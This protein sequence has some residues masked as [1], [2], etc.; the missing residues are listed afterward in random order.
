ML[1]I[2]GSYHE[3]GGQIVRTALGLSVLT[4]IPFVC[5]DIRKGRADSGLKAQHLTAIQTFKKLSSSKCDGAELGSTEITFHPKPIKKYSLEIDIGTAGSISLLL[6]SLLPALVFADKKICLK[7]TGGTDVAWA[8]P[9]DYLQNLLAPQLMRFANIKIRQ[10]KKGYYPKGGGLV[11]LKITPKI[12]RN[13]CNSFDDFVME[14]RKNC[15]PFALEKQ[16]KLLIVRG[17]SHSSNDL[18]NAKVAERQ[19]SAAK[20]VLQELKCPILINSGYYNT[21]ST[22]SGIMAYAIFGNKEEEEDSRNPIRLGADVLGEKG[23]K[24]EIVGE[25]CAKKLIKE[26]ETKGAVDE[27]LV[28]NLLPFLALAGGKICTTEISSHAKTNIYAIEKFLGPTFSIKD[29]CISVVHNR[30]E[31]I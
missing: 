2:D 3:G 21:L 20:N 18:Q 28:D 4:G 27:H 14:I 12:K 19:A 23:K 15:N 9:I 16:D 6:Q 30:V 10:T 1:E 25:E 26:I 31:K 7:I 17:I 8:M 11:E 13:T 29:N 24:A 5:K 22:G